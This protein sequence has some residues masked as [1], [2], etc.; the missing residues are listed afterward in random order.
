MNNFVNKLKPMLVFSAKI[1]MFTGMASGC[2]CG[3]RLIKV[4][5]IQPPNNE[6]TGSCTTTYVHH[7]LPLITGLLGTVF[8]PFV[9]LCS[10]LA[11]V[12]YYGQLC[13]MDKLYDK[14][15][16]KFVFTCNRYHQYGRGDDKYYAP[17]HLYI[18]ITNNLT[19]K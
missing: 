3:N 15:S 1:G 17:S 4:D 12:D 7:S 10:P 14:I 9:I 5:F 18:T 8:F 13:T 19:P 2:F 6:H 11:A 16:S